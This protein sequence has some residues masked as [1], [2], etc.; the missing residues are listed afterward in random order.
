MPHFLAIRNCPVWDL[1]DSAIVCSITSPYLQNNQGGYSCRT[2]THSTEFRQ[3][4][5]YSKLKQRVDPR[6]SYAS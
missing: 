3:F 6:S 1:T 4:A 2:Y 5:L